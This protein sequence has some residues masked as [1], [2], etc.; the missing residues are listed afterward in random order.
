M[1]MD[2]SIQQL[3]FRAFEIVIGLAEEGTYSKI[4]PL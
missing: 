1:L 2:F 3:E 4:D